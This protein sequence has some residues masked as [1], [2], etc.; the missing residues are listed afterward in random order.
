MIF[1]QAP[2]TKCRIKVQGIPKNILKGNKKEEL[3]FDQNRILLHPFQHNSHFSIDTLIEENNRRTKVK[4]MFED[5]K[6]NLL[7]QFLNESYQGGFHQPAQF[8]ECISNN[9]TSI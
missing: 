1:Q 7:D 2:Q 6:I 8:C 9:E 3:K 5:E 4:E